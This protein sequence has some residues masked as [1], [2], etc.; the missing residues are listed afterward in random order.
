MNIL[1]EIKYI[2]ENLEKIKEK[3]NLNNFQVNQTQR[4]IFSRMEIKRTTSK[5]DKIDIQTALDKFSK[6][7]T[8]SNKNAFRVTYLKD[9]IQFMD[10]KTILNLTLVNKEFNY[11]LLSIYFYK[12]MKQIKNYKTN[13]NKKRSEKIKEKD[14]EKEKVKEK[15]STQRLIGNFVGAFSNVLG[16]IFS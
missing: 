5:I 13:L 3:L 10:L 6:V 15:S 1:A 14:S 7:V 2:N 9:S 16:K 4:S 11:F 12:F 8:K